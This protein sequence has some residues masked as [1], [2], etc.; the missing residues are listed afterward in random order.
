ANNIIT[1]LMLIPSGI[2]SMSQDI[3]DL[4]ESSNN[5]GV[6]KTYDDK[7]TIE[8]AMRSSVGSLKSNIAIQLRLIAHAINA[9]WLSTSAYPAWEYNKDSYIREVFKKSYKELY[10]K[11]LGVAAIHAGL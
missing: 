10:N 8:C 4:V 9:D 6:L 2:Q 3:K 7:V 1:A 11:E 5:L